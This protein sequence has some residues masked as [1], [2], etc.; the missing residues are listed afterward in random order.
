MEG[1]QVTLSGQ[2][3]TIGYLIDEGGAGA[4]YEATGPNGEHAAAK[5]VI[6]MRTSEREFDFT[7]VTGS[8]LM[9]ILDTG[10]HRGDRVI[11]MPRAEGNLKTVIEQHP[12]GMPID[13]AVPILR[14]IATGLAQLE[15][16][17]VVHRDIK[18]ANILRYDGRWIIADFGVARYHDAQT[19]SLTHRRHF[20]R[21]YGAPEQWRY[22]RATP[23]TDIYA[24]GYLAYELLHGTRLFHDVEYH[25]DEL[26]ETHCTRPVDLTGTPPLMYSLIERS[27]AK[28]PEPR[29]SA[30]TF[31]ADL[32]RLNTPDESSIPA[33]QKLIDIQQGVKREREEWQRLQEAE[34]RE[35]QR[36]NELVEI[37][38][39]EWIRISDEFVD[40]ISRFRDLETGATRRGAGQWNVELRMAKLDFSG[41]YGAQRHGPPMPYTLIAGAHAS[42]TIP[43]VGGT[44]TGRA[45]SIWY[46]DLQHEGEFGWYEIAFA[47]APGRKRG[48]TEPFDQRPSWEAGEI[49]AGTNKAIQLAWPPTPWRYGDLREPIT[50]WA[51][52]F[53][54][55]ADGTLERPRQIPERPV[56]G[57]F[58]RPPPETP[59]PS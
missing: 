57:T 46:G 28:R 7:A 18:P 6:G 15:E 51:T 53:A 14:D 22:E 10:Q 1:T 5:F 33:I 39:Q 41:V 17:K 30:A 2:T 20:T 40:T 31:L 3:W 8:H 37:A 49:L 23:K 42:L 21:L 52:W 36:F 38:K 56:E 45:H 26:G 29:P 4:V 50:R 12:D 59:S 55:A 54:Q 43:R 9:Q 24:L 35:S 34:E 13:Q 44:Y 48:L 32:D 11:L 58:R 47:A 19:A 27:L 16:H 25:N